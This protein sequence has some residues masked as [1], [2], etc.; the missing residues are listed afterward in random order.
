MNNI[1]ELR[2]KKVKIFLL[3]VIIGIYLFLQNNWLDKEEIII[4]MNNLPIEL[5]GFKIVQ[6][7][8]LHIPQNEIEIGKLTDLVKKENPDVIVLTGDTISRGTNLDYSQ[9]ELL[10]DDLSDITKV[11]A[12]LGNH[13]TGN[14]YI[15]KYK[16]LLKTHNITL[17]ENEF[18][19]YA[20]GGKEIAFIGLKDNAKL[21]QEKIKNIE[22]IKGKPIVMLAHRPELFDEYFRETNIIIPS[23]VLTGHAHGGQFRLP[24]TKRGFIAPN[25]GLF[26]KYTS[27]T[28]KSN[29]GGVMIV[30]RGLGRSVIPFRINNRIHLPVIELKTR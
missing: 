23:L 4:E 19:I 13:E 9:L 3:L 16:E 7:S 10:F 17:L 20:K 15:E 14:K 2:I 5:D 27:G 26:P 24:F 18:D 30:S 6:I 21:S 28:Y 29:N 1:K 12:V 8:D 25:Q 22:K 11:Y